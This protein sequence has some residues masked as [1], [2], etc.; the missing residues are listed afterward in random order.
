VVTTIAPPSAFHCA[1]DATTGAM[2]WP[3]AAETIF[4]AI[5]ANGMIY[6]SMLL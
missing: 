1:L 4:S 5:L 3:Y 2:P 6:A